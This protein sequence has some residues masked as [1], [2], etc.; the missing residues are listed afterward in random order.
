MTRKTEIESNEREMWESWKFLKLLAE[1]A[2]I[3]GNNKEY[4]KETN[5]YSNNEIQ[6]RAE[7]TVRGETSC[8]WN[9][10]VILSHFFDNWSQP[11]VSEFNSPIHHYYI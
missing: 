3:L 11:Q 9:L 4:L 7:A 8:G 5:N 10:S 2:V 1:K 6:T